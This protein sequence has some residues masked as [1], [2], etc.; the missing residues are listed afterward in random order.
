VNDRDADIREVLPQLERLDGVGDAAWWHESRL[1]FSSGP[2]L[3]SV[4]FVGLRQAERSLK[5]HFRVAR[6]IEGRVRDFWCC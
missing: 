2:L 1:Y 6:T 3:L 4:Q 5:V